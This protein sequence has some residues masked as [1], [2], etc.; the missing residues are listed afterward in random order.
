MASPL[1]AGAK[2][3]PLSNGAHSFICVIFNRTKSGRRVFCRQR[4]H[5]PGIRRSFPRKRQNFYVEI[6][7]S[8]RLWNVLCHLKTMLKRGI[9]RSP[10]ETGPRAIL[11][12]PVFVSWCWPQQLATM[13]IR[14]FRNSLS[15][16]NMY[17]SLKLCLQRVG[18][19]HQTKQKFGLRNS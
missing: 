18:A 6:Q 9:L 7:I 5:P 17:P 3:Y 14:H 13:P 4:L 11:N 15:K 1:P 16:Q 19:A 12:S 8:P 2:T 10:M